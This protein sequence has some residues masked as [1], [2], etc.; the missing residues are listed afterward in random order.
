MSGR[1]RSRRG[2]V[3]L[4]ALAVAT[5]GYGLLQ[6]PRSEF[7]GRQ[8]DCSSP[9]GCGFSASG[10]SVRSCLSDDMASADM[11]HI[12]GVR[13]FDQVLGDG[14]GAVVGQQPWPMEPALSS[15][16]GSTAISSAAVTSSA[17][18][19]VHSFQEKM[20]R[21]KSSRTVDG[22]NFPDDLEMSESRLPEFAWRRRLILELIVS[23]HHDE[24]RVGD[25]I[26]CLE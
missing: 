8:A 2:R 15:P 7:P 10:A 24:G 23:L 18:I 17:L 16:A 21:E 9:A 26:L 4:A 5:G 19:V 13:P 20:Q 3:R 11:V 22:W 12:L 6:R 1:D 14:W 25:Q